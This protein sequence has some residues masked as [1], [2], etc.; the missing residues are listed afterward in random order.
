MC[1]CSTPGGILRRGPGRRPHAPHRSGQSGVRLP[2]DLDGHDRGKVLDLQRRKAD[3][4]P[5]SWTTRPCSHSRSLPM[6]SAAVRGVSRLRP[7]FGGV[8]RVRSCSNSGACRSGGGGLR[9]VGP[10][11][12]AANRDP[13]HECRDRGQQDEPR[14]ADHPSAIRTPL[15]N[16]TKPFHPTAT[17]SPR[18]RGAVC[19]G[20]Y[21]DWRLSVIVDIRDPG[22]PGP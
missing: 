6:T 21:S 10:L 15:Q 17:A 4:S 1:S 2:H 19:G 5:L 3:C 22:R 8:V 14:K 13:D 7:Q 9:G 16:A 18:S 20:M 12:P 11:P